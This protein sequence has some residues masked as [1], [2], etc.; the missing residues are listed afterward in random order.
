[1][2]HALVLAGGLGERLWPLSRKQTKTKEAI[3]LA[4]NTMLELTIARLSQWVTKD[5]IWIVSSKVIPTYGCKLIL[6]PARKNTAAAVAWGLAQILA[7]DKD[8]FVGIFP[9]DHLISPFE[10]VI[11]A[12]YDIKTQ[13]SITA[14]AICADKPS[15]Q[16]GY[17]KT[18]VSDKKMKKVVA[19]REKPENPKEL[20]EAGYYINSGIYAAWA[21]KLLA[22]IGCFLPRHFRAAQSR[23][24]SLFTS[25]YPVSLDRGV[26]EKSKRLFG[27]PLKVFWEDIGSWGSYLKYAGEK[28]QFIKHN[29]DNS[30]VY[31]EDTL[32]V[33][34]GIRDALVVVKDGIVLVMKKEDE[35][36]IPQVLEEIRQKYPGFA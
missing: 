30:L 10:N 32:V 16:Y 27:Y 22:E 18:E 25:L 19:F 14:L 15:R 24:S 26:I 28:G 13:G 36:Q 7:I 17:F 33:L 8:A 2:D 20:L 35:S 9:I 11:E 5:R 34:D 12:L 31:A 23:D 3:N 29:S 4:S 21:R 6:E 1:M